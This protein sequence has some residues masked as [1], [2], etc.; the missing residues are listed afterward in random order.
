MDSTTGRLARY[1]A[2][3]RMAAVT[4]L[5]VRILVAASAVGLASFVLVAWVLGPMTPVVWLCIGWAA[6]FGMI[7]AA[8]AWSLQPLRKL[9]GHGALGLVATQD[10]ALLSPLQSA[11]ELQTETAFS[12]E[13]VVAQRLGLLRTLDDSPA[14]KFI[15]WQWVVQPAFAAA[16]FIGVIAWWSLGFDRAL[17]GRYA[18]LHVEGSPTGGALVSHV[19]AHT[20]A[21]LVFPDYVGRQSEHVEDAD[22]LMVPRGTSVEYSVTPIGDAA[23]VV[24]GLPGR[25]AQADRAGDLFVASF[26]ADIEGPIEIY[27][28]STA[29]ERRVDYRARSIE[30]QADQSPLVLLAEPTTDLVVEARDPVALRHVASDDYGVQELTLIIKL[31]NGEHL[32]RPLFGPPED[33][34]KRV[35]G[36]TTIYLDEFSLSP[37]DVITVWFEAKDGNRIDGPG[38]GRSEDRTLTLASEIT[39]RR[40]R[41]VDLE[42]LLDSLLE[43][44]AVRLEQPVTRESRGAER[45]HANVSAAL[46]QTLALLFDVG[47]HP[48]PRTVPLLLDMRK[49][50][51][52][53]QKREAAAHEKISNYPYRKR[54]DKTFVTEL[55]NDSILVA[56]LIS[57][58][59]LNDAVAIAH[60]MRELQREIASL[61]S[62]LRRG[63]TPELQR[64]LMAA[65]D[66][67]DRRMQ[68]LKRQLLEV[69]QYVPGEFVNRQHIQARQST[70]ALKDLRQALAEGDLDAAEEALARLDQTIDAMIQA[71]S[72]SEDSLAETKFGPRER[73]LMDALDSIRDLEVEQQRMADQAR[74][75]G[76]NATRRAAEEADRLGSDAQKSLEEK[77]REVVEQIEALAEEALGPYEQNLRHRAQERLDDFQQA[78]ESGDL[79]EALSMANKAAQAAQALAKD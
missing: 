9:R 39:R 1:R 51:E 20:D 23:R 61:I 70:D 57:Q 67:A 55:E 69:M 47:D 28:E 36:E 64:A 63:Q 49:R 41:I 48:G 44:L 73:A 4:V 58:A 14:R 3:L 62:E 74:R 68:A 31:P 30:V 65:L 16:I 18:L 8:V 52:R 56:D 33:P 78:L 11:Y 77:A 12:R 24:V 66:R 72:Q 59:R 26:V 27:V 25:H 60:E 53:I 54:F 15:P 38:V 34:Q 50:L 6:V 13:L 32:R 43:A 45:R 40:D 42:K 35:Q 21:V 76:D 71:L 17:A 46:E 5:A 22:H 37:A 79:G 7:A 2:R 10:P 19:V 75:I 29:G